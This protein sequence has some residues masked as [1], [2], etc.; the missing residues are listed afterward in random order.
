MI[1]FLG[2]HFRPSSNNPNH[3]HFQKLKLI[4]LILTNIPHQNVTEP[5][6]QTFQTSLNI[7]QTVLPHNDVMTSNIAVISLSLSLDN[8]RNSH[9]LLILKQGHNKSMHSLNGNRTGSYNIELGHWNKGNSL[10]QNK[11]NDIN[12]LIDQNR[13]DIF[14]I[15]EAN[16]NFKKSNILN[17]FNNFH[18]ES[19]QDQRSTA[20]TQYQ[21]FS[22]S[23]Q[24]SA[25]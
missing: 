2:K 12:L 3:I 9:L 7:P 4:I 6:H 11:V 23:H 10:I 15:S 8:F 24:V 22:F 18:I 19:K 17:E 16:L 1:S 14:S 21:L 5:P 20:P 25:I 13:P